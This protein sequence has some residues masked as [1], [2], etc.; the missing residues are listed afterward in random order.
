MPQGALAPSQKVATLLVGVHAPRLR[1][2]C[3]LVVLAAASLDGV[4]RPA[5]LAI[6][7]YDRREGITFAS[8]S[9][10][11]TKFAGHRRSVVCF[12]VVVVE[13]VECDSGVVAVC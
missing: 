7:R 4:V 5:A 1:S 2:E 12:F 13:P 9:V 11:R 3:R 6:L 10:R 8:P